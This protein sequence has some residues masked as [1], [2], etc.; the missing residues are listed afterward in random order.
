M[1]YTTAEPLTLIGV[2]S[3]ALCAGEA[4][5]LHNRSAHSLRT[6]PQWFDNVT[7][8]MFRICPCGNFHIDPDERTNRQ[9]RFPAP[10]CRCNR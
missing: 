1:Y 6:C 7:G 8:I 2:H 10:E 4:C 3:V 5:T 9:S